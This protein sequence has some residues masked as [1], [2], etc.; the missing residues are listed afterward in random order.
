[1]DFDL[2]NIFVVYIGSIVFF[3]AISV[4]PTDG[5]FPL[6]KARVMLAMREVDN[7]QN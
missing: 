6:S 2:L 7:Q 5:R 1:M 4:V 3:R